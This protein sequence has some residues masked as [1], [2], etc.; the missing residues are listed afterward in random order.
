MKIAWYSNAPWAGT[1]YGQQ[2]DIFTELLTANGH[3]V[4]ILANYGLN[5]APRG[6]K[7]MPVYPGGYDMWANDVLSLHSRHHFNESNGLILTLCDVWVIKNPALKQMPMASWV[8]IDHTP[9]PPKV[10]Q[11]FAEYNSHPIAM[12]K[13]G[14]AELQNL[15]FDA[16]YVPHGIDTDVFRPVTEIGGR[17][18][19][20]VLG[21]PADA[22]V[23]GMN[24]ANKG[25]Q[26]IRKSFPQV[27][28]AFAMFQRKRPDAILYL[29]TEKFGHSAGVDL[30]RL[31]QACGVPEDSIMYTD[32]YAY[33]MG[34]KPEMLA[35]MYSAFDVLAS[36]SMGEGFGIPVV[37]AQ[38]C[39]VPVIVS[40]AT[41]Q[42]ELCGSGWTVGGVPDWDEAQA[43]WFHLPDV[44]EIAAAMDEAYEGQGDREKARQFALGYH[45]TTV[46]E[47]HWVP[48]LE[49]LATMVELPSVDFEVEPVRFDG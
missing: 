36:P 30:I 23:V 42:P 41:A 1:G 48:V 7:G 39:G 3:D 11:F 27:F 5:G 12:S 38:A 49:R 17:S 44:F 35:A 22:F 6:W 26:K 47:D 10:A 18:V 2:T 29:H 40:D 9:I 24:A 31:A 20:E 46:Y 8:P 16:S 15:G 33:R 14:L 13:F 25:S 4:A 43:S 19:R 21:L 34:L 45:H 37:E 32:Q 28:L